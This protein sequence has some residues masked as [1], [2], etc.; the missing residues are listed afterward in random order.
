MERHE[1]EA[2]LA[3]TGAQELLASTAMAHSRM[4]GRMPRHG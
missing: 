1:I 4:P 3:T 2:E